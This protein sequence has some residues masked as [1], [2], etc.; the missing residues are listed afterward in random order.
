MT[1]AIGRRHFHLTPALIKVKMKAAF[2]RMALVDACDPRHIRQ[3]ICPL[4][5]V[6][7]KM[8]TPDE[9]KRMYALCGQIVEERNSDKFLRLVTELT[10]L[11][12]HKDRRLEGEAVPKPAG[13]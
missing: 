13:S 2:H 9:R 7:L 3:I 11:L 1:L 4:G 10:E 12:D 8:L 6:E 5:V